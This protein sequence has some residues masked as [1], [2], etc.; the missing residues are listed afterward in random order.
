MQLLAVALC[1]C[2][3][4]CVSLSQVGSFIEMAERFE[5]VSGTG[6]SSRLPYT[7]LKKKFGYLQK[8]LG[9][10]KVKFSHTR[11]RALGPELIPVYRQSARR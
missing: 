3:Y 5:L 11:Y 4:V 8:G 2:L 9:P 1:L 10:K 6:V 7:V